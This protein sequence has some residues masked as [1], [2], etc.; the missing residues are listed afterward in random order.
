MIADADRDPWF[1]ADEAVGYGLI[2]HVLDRA[3]GLTMI[4]VSERAAG[5]GQLRVPGH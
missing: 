2:D 3:W 4:D 5:R 1:S